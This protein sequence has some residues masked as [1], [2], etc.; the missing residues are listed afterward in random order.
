[1]SHWL[2]AAWRF[3]GASTF[4]FP[5]TGKAS[6]RGRFFGRRRP[7]AIA[8]DISEEQRA[9]DPARSIQDW[10]EWLMIVRPDE[11]AQRHLERGFDSKEINWTSA[12]AVTLL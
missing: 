9:I 10:I 1:M 12:P 8:V 7:K 11:Q 6:R 2:P 3:A 4:Y 5:M